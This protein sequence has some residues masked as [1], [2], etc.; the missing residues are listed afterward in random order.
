MLAYSNSVAGRL[1]DVSAARGAGN[2]GCFFGGAGAALLAATLLLLF[3]QVSI[4]RTSRILY[5][6]L[7]FFPK[8][9]VNVDVNI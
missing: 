5:A 6:G 8:I 7:W 1:S 9:I 3:S 4:P 2:I